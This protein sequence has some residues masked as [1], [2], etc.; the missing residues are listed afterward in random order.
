[1]IFASLEDGSGLVDVAFFEDSHD[2]CAHTV[3]H[4]GL[5]LVRSTVQ[6]RGP[7][8]TVVG[9]MVWDLDEL[10]AARRDHGPEAALRILGQRT[11]QP[12]PAQVP[13]R[14]LA[15]GTAGARLHPYADLEPAG[16]RSADLKA[17]GYTSLGSPH[18]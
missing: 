15:N 6:R 9:S 18:L 14:T 10:A 7:R 4:A 11:P 8:R 3:F 1:M 2:Q 12:T 13:Q 17:L 5:L 16:T